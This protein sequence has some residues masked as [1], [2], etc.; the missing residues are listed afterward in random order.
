MPMKDPADVF[1]R[2]EELTSALRTVRAHLRGGDDGEEFD[3]F[4]VIERSVETIDRAL[5]D[6]VPA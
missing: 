4:D 3:P 2:I 6:R 1:A 5:Q